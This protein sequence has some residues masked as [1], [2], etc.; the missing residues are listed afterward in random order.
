[1]S[2]RIYLG[3]LVATAAAAYSHEPSSGLSAVTLSILHYI[4]SETTFP[5]A[6]CV[7]RSPGYLI[8]SRTFLLGV[9]LTDLGD[10]GR[11]LGGNKAIVGVFN[12]PIVYYY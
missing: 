2:S 6:L 4:G 1:M 5:S 12:G 11:H 7:I 8:W 3:T 10:L 9:G